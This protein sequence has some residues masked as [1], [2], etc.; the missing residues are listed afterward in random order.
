MRIERLSLRE[1]AQAARGTTVI[2]DV[3][4]A[5]TCEPL[6]YH[7]GATKL[8][9]EA[10]IKRCLQHQGHCLLV[11]EQNEKPIQGFDLINSPHLIM[12][13]GHA[14]F[15]GKSVI[16]RST[17]G[18]TGAVNALQHADEVLLAS[19][20]N[21]R[22]T[23]H[24]IRRVKP[25]HVSIVAMGILSS[26]PAPEDE[27]CGDYIESLL[28]DKPY[29]HLAAIKEI[30]A[31]ETGQ[32]FLRGDKVFLPPEDAAICIQRDLFDFVLRAER[33]GD[34]VVARKLTP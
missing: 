7:L 5:F 17:S 13:K 14:F 3:F 27:R 23:A 9:L 22:A 6:M 18:V 33:D 26:Q 12:A 20:V 25:S 24:Y 8:M 1:G 30:L 10:D 31:H 15:Q 21:A 34:F 29:D 32:K 4:R 19:F 28:N 2:I 11:G 16:H